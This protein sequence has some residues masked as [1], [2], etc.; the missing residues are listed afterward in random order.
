VYTIKQKQSKMKGL[1]FTLLVGVI[2]L[3]I[4]FK[5]IHPRVMSA[6][7]PGGFGW[8]QAAA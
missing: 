3:A 4:Y 8:S 7:I 6:E 2:L 5:F 1:F